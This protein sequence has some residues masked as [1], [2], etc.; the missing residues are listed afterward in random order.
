MKKQI[1]LTIPNIL[2]LS[3]IILAPLLIVAGYFGIEVLFFMIFGLMLLSDVLDGFLARI[4]HQTSEIGAKLDSYGDIATYLTAPLAA[5]LLW[6]ELMYAQR[7]YIFLAIFIYVLPALFALI[8]FHQLVNY[9]T[10]ITKLSAVVMCVGM[11]ILFVFQN[12]FLFHVAILILCIEAIEN[13]L[14]T[15]LIDTPRSDVRSLWHIYHT[16]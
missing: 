9:H 16:K 7:Y 4:L 8:K 15:L 6:P 5:W 3:R 1:P 11:L 12:P 10:W 14:I 2:S 13:I